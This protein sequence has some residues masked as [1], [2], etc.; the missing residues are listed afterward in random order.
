MKFVEPWKILL[1]T[2][3]FFDFVGLKKKQYNSS[4]YKTLDRLGKISQA[5][6]NLGEILKY[7]PISYD[8]AISPVCVLCNPNLLSILVMTTFT[9]PLITK[10]EKRK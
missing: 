8:D 4:F 5:P 2:G 7:I 1:H 9:K 6:R 10:P 3:Q